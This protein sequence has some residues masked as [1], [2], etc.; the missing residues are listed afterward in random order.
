[1]K[2][3]IKVIIFFATAT[4][5][6]TSCASTR[7]AK[8]VKAQETQISPTGFQVVTLPDGTELTYYNGVL[9]MPAES[10]NGSST[11]NSGSGANCGTTTNNGS[12][13]NC[14]TGGAPAPKVTPWWNQVLVD[15]FENP[16]QAGYGPYA[17]IDEGA[18][19]N[20]VFGFWILESASEFC[21]VAQISSVAPNKI[22]EIKGKPVY[23]YRSLYIEYGNVSH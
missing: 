4:F 13:S 14:A 7:C 23:S 17:H 20:K 16:E 2:K 5:F 9:L 15:D 3:S 18:E 6:F 11:T 10:Q 22:G 8:N 12:S 19:H 1:M 21:A